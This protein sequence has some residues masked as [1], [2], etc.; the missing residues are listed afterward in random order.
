MVK[1]WFYLLSLSV[2]VLVESSR[3][4][5]ICHGDP[6]E[7]MLIATARQHGFSLVTRDEKILAYAVKATWK[8][9]LHNFDLPT[10]EFQ[11]TLIV[12]VVGLNPLRFHLN[13]TFALNFKRFPLRDISGMLILG[14][15]L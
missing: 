14:L 2:N 13:I 6:V 8:L 11:F 7:R 12:P 4:P 10:T 1:N 9:F 5:G 15:V 3:L